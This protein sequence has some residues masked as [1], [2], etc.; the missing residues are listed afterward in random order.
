VTRTGRQG[1]TD[2]SESGGKPRTERRNR[3]SEVMAAAIQIFHAKGYSAASIQ[4]VADS[5]GVLK[6]SLYHYISKKEDLLFQIA[7]ESHTQAAEII[8]NVEKQGGP[9]L[10][11]LKRFLT[12]IMTWYLNNIERVSI[13]FNEGR[14][15][16]GDR[17]QELQRD[18][19]SFEGYVRRLLIDAAAEGTIRHS[20]DPKLASLF[21]LGALNS[22]ATWYRKG[23]SFAAGTV[24]KTYVDMILASLV[25][26]SADGRPVRP[27]LPGC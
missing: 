11:R 7:S 25:E 2:G 5:V 15:L 19:R 20:V 21:I 24:T 17:L 1:E 6:G 22:V 3:E 8:A 4:D 26:S 27:H 9:A 14:Y 10:Q 18:R 12:D 13:Y 16:T 23:G